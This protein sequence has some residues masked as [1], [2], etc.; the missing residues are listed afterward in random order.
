[1]SE[2]AKKY[3][4][5]YWSEEDQKI[6]A[7]A[8][9]QGRADAWRWREYPEEKPEKGQAVLVLDRKTDKHY[10]YWGKAYYDEGEFIDDDCVP[11]A[12]VTYWL[13]I[14]LPEGER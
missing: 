1:M 6:A 13:P 11:L 10:E 4:A 9:D 8:Y 2:E 3:A 14:T 12:N 7:D 5:R